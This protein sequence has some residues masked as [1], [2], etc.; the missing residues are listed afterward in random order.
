MTLPHDLMI[1]CVHARARAAEET[2]WKEIAGLYD[3]LAARVPSPVVELNRAVAHGMAFGPGKGLLMADALAGNPA[4]QSYH[5]LP[6]VRGDL[7]EKLERFEEAGEEFERAA[8]R[9]RNERER[10]VLLARS[11]RA[12]SR[13]RRSP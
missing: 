6:A 11:S 3:A 2:D 8:S 13:A 5:L 10:S 4:L 1:R 12:R 9:T 7:L